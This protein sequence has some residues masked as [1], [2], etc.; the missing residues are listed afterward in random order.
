MS[1]ELV[2]PTAYSPSSAYYLYNKSKSKGCGCGG[3][4]KESHDG[5]CSDCGQSECG[6][7]KK[8][9][10]GCP[11]IGLVSVFDNTGKFAGFL[12]PSDAELFV[13]NTMKCDIGYS[14]M[15]NTSSGQFIGCV[16]ESNYATMYAIINP[17]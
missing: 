10:C 16:S 1:Q 7:E 4:K 8:D 6:C 11:P 2:Q 5:G 15:F 14:K 9:G 12:N 17:T 3:K 13:Q